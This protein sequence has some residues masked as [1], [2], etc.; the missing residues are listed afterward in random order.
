MKKIVFSCVCMAAVAASAGM[1]LGA[2]N[3]EILI[4]NLPSHE[5]T[6]ALVKST[7]DD[8]RNKMEARQE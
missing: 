8:Y 4:K 2:V 3:L 6:R 5:S 1:K 7:A